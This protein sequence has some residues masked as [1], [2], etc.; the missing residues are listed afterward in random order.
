MGLCQQNLTRQTH[1]IEFFSVNNQY[2]FIVVDIVVLNKQQIN[3]NA[4]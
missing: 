1:R 3:D 2:L 4:E